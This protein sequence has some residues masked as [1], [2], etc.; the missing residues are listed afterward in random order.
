MAKSCD[1]YLQFHPLHPYALGK[2]LKI[3]KK[4]ISNIIMFGK[5]YTILYLGEKERYLAHSLL[6]S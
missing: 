5:I 6:Q 3:C 2:E 4:N 1:H